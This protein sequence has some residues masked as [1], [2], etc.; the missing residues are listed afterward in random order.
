M[1]PGFGTPAARSLLILPIEWFNHKTQAQVL[2]GDLSP[3]TK[4]NT[5]PSGL[6]WLHFR[7]ASF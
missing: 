2:V 7:G 6:S 4:Q 5:S 1:D 3:L